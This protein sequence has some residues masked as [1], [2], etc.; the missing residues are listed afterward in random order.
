MG[1][2][3]GGLVTRGK[4]KKLNK[5]IANESQWQ[6]DLSLNTM[7]IQE[8]SQN[9]A[10]VQANLQMTQER[11]QAMRE[12]RIRRAEV[13]AAASNAGGLTSTVAQ[14]A[15]DSIYTQLVAGVGL[16]NVFAGFSE[17]QSQL[18]KLIAK[19][20]SEI[21]KSQGR[22]NEFQ[23]RIG[24]Q[25]AKA[26]LIGGAIDL[27]LGAATAFLGPAGMFAATAGAATGVMSG[28]SKVASGFTSAARVV[29]NTVAN[30]NNF[31]SGNF[32]NTNPF[33]VNR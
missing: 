3:I 29:G 24:K 20:N 27:G 6:Q 13:I 31:Q 23:A 11:I 18:N 32:N 2:F 9:V 16:Q 21:I 15:S 12:A 25:Q 4:I 1:S 17:H 5:A 8:E 22:Q 10:Q 19:N 33:G 26:E 7:D 30:F 28:A 14:G